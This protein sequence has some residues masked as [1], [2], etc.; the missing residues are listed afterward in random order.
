[1]D[2]D[3]TSAIY[4]AWPVSSEGAATGHHGGAVRATLARAQKQ[5]TKSLNPKVSRDG[6]IAIIFRIVGHP[7]VGTLTQTQSI[8][9]GRASRGND[10]GISMFRPRRS[11][12]LFKN[13]LAV[14]R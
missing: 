5:T 10:G 12:V 8:Q 3:T 14:I 2:P 6:V 9:I 4:S 11:I 7:E 1:M 13:H